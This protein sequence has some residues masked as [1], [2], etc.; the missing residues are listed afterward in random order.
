MKY[1]RINLGIFENYSQVPLAN[2]M[3][4]IESIRKRL[5]KDLWRQKKS[6]EKPARLRVES[7]GFL[8]PAFFLI[9]PF[10]DGGDFRGSG[11]T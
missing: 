3:R 7:A 4:C 1:L 10:R 8:R 2:K 5:D 9:S 6:S 11:L